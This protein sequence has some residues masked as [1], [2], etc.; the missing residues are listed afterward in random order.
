MSTPVMYYKFL[1]LVKIKTIHEYL[2]L[3]V[4]IVAV[5]P[6]AAVDQRKMTSS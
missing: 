3:L 4:F 6:L 2:Q 1:N 5:Q